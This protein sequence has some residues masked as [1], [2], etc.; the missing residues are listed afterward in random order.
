[1]LAFV[2]GLFIGGTLGVIGM[3]CVVLAGQDDDR[4][5]RG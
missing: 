2:I 4:H 3:A 5:G 1:M